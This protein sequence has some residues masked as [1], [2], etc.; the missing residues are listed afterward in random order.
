MAEE[1]RQE[2]FLSRIFLPGREASI[3]KEKIGPFVCVGK[4]RPR[5]TV[6]FGLAE[7]PSLLNVSATEGVTA[8]IKPSKLGS[9]ALSRLEG[10][11]VVVVKDK[12]LVRP[13]G[14][15]SHGFVGIY[16]LDETGEGIVELKSGQ[17]LGKQAGFDLKPNE[18][19]IAVPVYM[20]DK[21]GLFVCGE[22]QFRN[23][24]HKAALKRLFA[25]TDM[26]RLM[27]EIN[28]APWETESG[29]WES[30]WHK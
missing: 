4:E 2:G 20:A 19:V 12:V 14:A 13:G 22:S 1:S 8:E 11:T 15:H 21:K 25:G 7:M 18:M 10:K 30:F 23:R 6:I 3:A 24:K 26:N 29:D 16:G 5:R 17:R 9:R 28:E 27:V